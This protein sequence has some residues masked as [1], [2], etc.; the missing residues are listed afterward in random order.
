MESSGFFYSEYLTKEIR[1][2]AIEE[3]PR[4]AWVEEMK[5]R[6]KTNYDKLSIHRIGQHI[7]GSMQVGT[8]SSP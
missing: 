7:W 2:I 6:N 5:K 3:P 8:W 1:R 4:E